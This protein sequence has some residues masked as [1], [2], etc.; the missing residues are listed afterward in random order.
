MSHPFPSQIPPSPLSARAP[1][2]VYELSRGKLT[3]CLAEYFG[4]APPAGTVECDYTLWRCAETGFEFAWPAKAGS[5]AFYRWIGQFDFYYPGWR[6]E[7]DAVA[8][9]L[10]SSARGRETDFQVLDAGC[11]SGHFLSSLDFLPLAARRAVDFSPLAIAACA[12]KGLPGHCGDITA[13]LAAGFVAP[14]S[15]DAVTSFHCLEHVED[16]VG[17]TSQLLTLLKPGGTL[18]L[19]T[20]NSPLSFESA[21][22]DVMNHPPH[23]LGRWNPA[24]YQRLAELLGCRCEL[25]SPP[26]SALRQAL[27]AF[28]LA[29][30]G[31]HRPVGRAR[32]LLD[33]LTHCGRLV[34]LW[35][36]QKE[37]SRRL[38]RL[39]GD[40][41]LAR[42]T[43]APNA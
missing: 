13:A 26:V 14:R 25:F 3:D 35:R 41:I 23:H 15:L 36:H 18:W 43:P 4:E 24:A 8:A 10:R 6:W 17:F 39:A 32:L 5:E 34:S 33:A 27:G 1:V 37:R 31:A 21:W 22:F 38:Q 29:R 12:A 30:Y 2:R 20:P 19:S 16:P 9:R 28:R 40:V 42:L 7:Y 11:G